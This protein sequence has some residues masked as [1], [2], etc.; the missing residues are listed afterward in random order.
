[1]EQR[2]LGAGQFML[3]LEAAA[4][5]RAAK[6]GNFVHVQ[7]DPLLPMRRP[8]SI[9]LTDPAGGSLD[10]LYKVTGQGTA[11]LAAKRQQESLELLGPIGT[12]F[13]LTGYRHLPLLLGGGVGIPPILF[14]AKHIRHSGEPVQP[15]A[16][17]GS[18]V[19]FPFPLRPSSLLLPGIPAQA[20]ACMPMLEDWG[21]PSR[22]AS[23]ADF[24]G[25]FQGHVTELAEHWLSS[26]D[27]ERQGQVELFACGPE[28]MLV[29]TAAL[30]HRYG[31]PCQLAIEEFMACAVGGC[32]GCTVRV[33]RDGVVYMERVCV[34]GPV[35]EAKELYPD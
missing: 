27:V 20:T 14:L 23:G 32:A 21:L 15:L 1:M 28:S 24:P 13:K 2:E 8:M 25:C 34:D 19:V 5:A 12:P 26:L 29:A 18:E 35:F 11:L 22:L 10:I 6:P 30:A 3:R 7:C 16:L 17:L 31:L 9:M 33:Q 4:I